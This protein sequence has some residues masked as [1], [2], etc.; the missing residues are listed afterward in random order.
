MRMNVQNTTLTN[1]MERID[2]SLCNIEKTLKDMVRMSIEEMKN[3]T[4][5]EKELISL[6]DN[7]ANHIG[8]FFFE[9]CERT[10]N[11]RLYKDIVKYM[12]FNK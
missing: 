5:K 1:N 9:E 8:D 7:H 10:G 6:W 4:A 2:I 3:D 11:K 12:M